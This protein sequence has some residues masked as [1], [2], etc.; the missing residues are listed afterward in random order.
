MC[1]AIIVPRGIAAPS[2]ETLEAC[3]AANSHG[4]GIAWIQG[5]QVRWRKGL[6]TADILQ[7]MKYAPTP[8]FIH[9][10]IATAG[11][12]QEALCHPFGVD[13]AAS[14]AP[15]GAASAVLMHNGHWSE[16]RENMLRLLRGKVPKGPWSDSRAMAYIAYHYGTEALE[17]I[18]EKVA[19][20]HAD[21]SIERFGAGWQLR[22]DCWYS[23][24]SWRYTTQYDPREWKPLKPRKHR[25][26]Y[27]PRDEGDEIDDLYADTPS[28]YL[29]TEMTQVQAALTV[30]PSDM[31]MVGG[32]GVKR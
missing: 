1:I 23:N 30:A 11:G 14:F 5:K 25:S 3:E 15:T 7:V 26:R 4:G 28:P 10:R 27:W 24:L 16:W 6:K 8:Y 32:N 22:N 21:G 18:D 31:L 17:L 29:D 9:F 20:L 19:V 13:K 2:Q 12:V